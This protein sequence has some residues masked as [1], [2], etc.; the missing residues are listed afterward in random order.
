[1]RLIHPCVIGV[2]VMHSSY[3]GFI[4]GVIDGGWLKVFISKIYL[5]VSE[6]MSKEAIVW[7]MR[8]LMARDISYAFSNEGHDI[9]GTIVHQ[10]S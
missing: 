4:Y 9:Y 6:D 8:T 3:G 7:E 10:S 1:M 5:E 2:F